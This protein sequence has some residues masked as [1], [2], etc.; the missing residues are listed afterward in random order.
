MKRFSLLIPAYNE[1]KCEKLEKGFGN[2]LV[3]SFLTG[4]EKKHS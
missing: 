3:T 2:S 4:I 1:K